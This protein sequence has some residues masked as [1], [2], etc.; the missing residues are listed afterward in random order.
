MAIQKPVKEIVGI[1]PAITKKPL[2]P[3]DTV[4]KDGRVILLYKDESSEGVP[5]MWKAS[6]K[7]SHTTKKWEESCWFAEIRSMQ[8]LDFTPK[9]WRER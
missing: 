6:R 9:F 8:P 4:P 3:I 2:H 7:F 5:S 1:P